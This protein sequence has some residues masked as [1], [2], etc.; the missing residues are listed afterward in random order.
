MED[1][2]VVG[3]SDKRE[4]K[5]RERSKGGM[6]GWGFLKRASLKEKEKR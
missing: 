4:E 2:G 1:D 3:A 6:T 5:A